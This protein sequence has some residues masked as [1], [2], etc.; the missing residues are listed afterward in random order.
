MDM[1]NDETT[2]TESMADTFF[3]F[4]SPHMPPLS[5]IARIDW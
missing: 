3:S 4:P 5:G 2:S 1:K